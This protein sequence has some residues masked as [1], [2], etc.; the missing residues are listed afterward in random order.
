MSKKI[1][2]S[3]NAIAFLFLMVSILLFVFQAFSVQTGSYC[4]DCGNHENCDNGNNLQTG[5]YYCE[6]GE[7]E[8]GGEWCYVDGWDDSGCAIQYKL[9]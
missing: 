3:K 7:F 1:I 8:S 2:H 9:A 6:R 4:K 5:Y